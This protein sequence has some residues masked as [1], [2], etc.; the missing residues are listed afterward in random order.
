MAAALRRLVP[1]AV[2]LA[3]MLALSR[4]MVHSGMI[5]VLATAAAGA[6]GLWPLFAAAVGATGTFVSGSATA[7]NILFTEFQVSTAAALG[8]PA[9]SALVRLDEL[10]GQPPHRRLELAEA[11]PHV[12]LLR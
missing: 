8:L 4:L 12:G 1:V 9:G 3:L 11:R 10:L 6:G 7:S 5:D 2:A